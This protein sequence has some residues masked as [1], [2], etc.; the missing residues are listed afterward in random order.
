MRSFSACTDR[1]P[2]ARDW[3]TGFPSA[4]L[5]ARTPQ[6]D[7]EGQRVRPRPTVEC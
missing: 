7:L 6:I 2:P 5:A 1:S 3:R 4:A